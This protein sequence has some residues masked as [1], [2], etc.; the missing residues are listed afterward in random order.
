MGFKVLAYISVVLLVSCHSVK[1]VKQQVEVPEVKSFYARYL[2]KDSSGIAYYDCESFVSIALDEYTIPNLNKTFGNSVKKEIVRNSHD[3][4][5]VD[6]IYSYTAPNSKIQIYR[7]K[8]NDFVYS[9]DVADPRFSLAN[10]VKSGMP[11]AGFAEMF[12]ISEPLPDY[13]VIRNT[14]ASIKF[15]FYFSADTLTRINSY[16][17][18]D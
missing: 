1:Q 2:F 10:Q 3:F 7:A 16:I 17:Y 4:T 15:L 5:E 18:L 11:K 8:Q 13:V 6:T 14:E 12:H 9:F